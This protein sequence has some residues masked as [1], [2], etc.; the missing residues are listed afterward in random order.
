[1]KRVLAFLLAML[2]IAVP[3]SAQT[4]PTKADA[5]YGVRYVEE[6][7][8]TLPQDQGKWYL[9]LFGNEGETK[10]E[11]LKS[12]FSTDSQLQGIR[13]QA[14]YNTYRADS[15]MFAERYATSTAVP[16]VRLQDSSGKVVFQVVGDAIPMSPQALYNS[17][18]DACR[19]RCRPCPPQP[20]PQPQP[21][22]P[23]TP[24]KPSPTPAPPALS[25]F[26]STGLWISMI[27]LGA[28]LGGG[29]GLGK[30]VK[31]EFAAK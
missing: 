10:Y 1:M 8:V 25:D 28:L 5:A 9:S 3:V 12:W 7:I 6:Q 15:T 18:S 27:A 2:V 29:I 26:P 23:V 21:Q 24:V 16:C 14:H 19:R 30:K 4:Q 20:T 22:P 13:T 11:T 17:M 31:E